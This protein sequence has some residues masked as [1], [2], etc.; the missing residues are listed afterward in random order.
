M[1]VNWP[2]VVIG[3]V[4]KDRREYSLRFECTRYP[5]VP[6]TAGLWDTERDQILAFDQWPRNSGGRV[7]AVF[8]SGWK[9]GTALY[10]PCDREAIAGHDNWRTEMPSK[11]WRSSDGIVQYLELVY[12]L[13]HCKDYQSPYIAP[14]H[15]LSCSWFL[16]RRLLRELRERGNCGRRESGAFLLGTQDF[17]KAR[18]V[19][20]LLYDDL[21]PN[22]LE[23]GI[24]HFDG[25]FFG[26]LWSVC[27]QRA[28]EVVADV[29][30]HP[31]CSQ[32]SDSDR[33]HPMITTRGH[34][35][36]ILPN[37]AIPRHDAKTSAYFD[38]WDPATGRPF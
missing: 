1:S 15:E 24:I 28:L 30:T 36:L 2:Y 9:S 25:R 11:I 31:G 27:E 6:P 5:Q 3:V 26:R 13:L 20:Y 12:E 34:I 19:D 14:R 17:G 22:C 37:F 18:I 4:A 32:Q 33:A 38:I 35:A 8:N 16:W 7:V 10:L 23:T 29:H 21:D